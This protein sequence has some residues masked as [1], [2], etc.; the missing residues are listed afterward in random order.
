MRAI[1][2][3]S[4]MIYGREVLMIAFAKQLA[5]KR[6][7]GVWRQPTPIHLLS[8]D[9]FNA[10]C[11]AAIEKPNVNGMYPLGDDGPTTLQEFL[12]TVCQHWRV[13]S[14]WC[15]PVWSVYF[16]AW[17][18]ETIASI[19]KTRSPFT[20]DFI[21]IGRVPYFCDT[22]RMKADLLPQLRYPS[23]QIGLELL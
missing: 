13:P 4:G 15:V 8:I 9:D 5:Q 23:L 11:Q 22:R 10:C 16:V 12:E 17:A 3:R 14:P 20:V 19:R 1:V 2:L 7:L 6:L 21:R 18:C